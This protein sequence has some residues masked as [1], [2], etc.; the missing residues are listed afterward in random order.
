MGD[1]MFDAGELGLV[2]DDAVVETALPAEG[3][4]LFAGLGGDGRFEAAHDGGEVAGM[5][6][7]LA[8]GARWV[9]GRML[10][11]QDAVEV[12]GHEDE[13]PRRDEGMKLGDAL[14]A[15]EGIGGDRGAD[16]VGR[17]VGGNVPEIRFAVG[18]ADS[19]EVG[20]GLTVV[21]TRPPGRGNAVL[22]LKE[23]VSR[24]WGIAHVK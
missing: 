18:S 2:A 15:G 13:G 12:I 10:K 17:R 14:P 22:I 1:V 11:K 20:P 9:T 4:L 5:G 23:A 16:E 19:D 21:V 8:A 24:G 6:T 3:D 7:E